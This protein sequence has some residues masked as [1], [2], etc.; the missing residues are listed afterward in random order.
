MTRAMQLRLFWESFAMMIDAGLPVLRALNTIINQGWGGKFGEGIRQ[1]AE[2]MQG[3]KTLS[4]AMEISKL[5]SKTEVNI[6]RAGEVGSI[7]EVVARRLTNGGLF[8]RADQYLYFYKNFGTL[9][10]SGVPILQSLKLSAEDLDEPLQIAIMK[11]Y[12]GVKEGDGM[13]APMEESGEF[14][15]MEVNLVDISDKC[16][17]LDAI[18]LKIVKLCEPLPFNR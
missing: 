13:A 8:T 3:G 17:C 15:P 11:I 18:L 7:L 9:I 16:G 14:S 1:I 6:I 10:T 12:D 4:E 5:F 2:D